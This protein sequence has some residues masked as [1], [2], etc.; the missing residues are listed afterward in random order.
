MALVSRFSE[1]VPRGE[2]VNTGYVVSAGSLWFIQVG[3]V[4]NGRFHQLAVQSLRSTDEP[5]SGYNAEFGSEIIYAALSGFTYKL[6][7]QIPQAVIWLYTSKSC[8]VP[9]PVLTL[10]D[11]G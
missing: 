1:Q 3:G 10:Y 6:G 11:I 5:L 8:P 4:G 9:D 7:D 2:S